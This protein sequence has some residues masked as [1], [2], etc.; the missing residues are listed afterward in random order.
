M[1]G[2]WSQLTTASGPRAVDTWYATT[3]D[4]D[5]AVIAL[6]DTPAVWLVHQPRAHVYW[7]TTRGRGLTLSLAAA[8]QRLAMVPMGVP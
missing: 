3:A 1:A 8:R 5:I 7:W 2:Q 6:P 4:G